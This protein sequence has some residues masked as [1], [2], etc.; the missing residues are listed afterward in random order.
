MRGAVSSTNISEN[1]YVPQNLILTAGRSLVS[2]ELLLWGGGVFDVLSRV[3][4][5]GVVDLVHW[6]RRSGVLS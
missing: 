3:A 1:A 5:G 6:P 4:P 2:R